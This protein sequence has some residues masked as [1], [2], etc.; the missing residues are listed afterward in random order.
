MRK[1][2]TDVAVHRAVTARDELERLAKAAIRAKQLP[3]DPFVHLAAVT[4]PPGTTC[5]LCARPLEAGFELDGGAG[6]VVLDARCFSSWINVAVTPQLHQAQ[7]GVAERHASACR[8]TPGPV[9]YT[10]TVSASQQ[11]RGAWTIHLELTDN[12]GTI[13][14]QADIDAVT[15]LRREDA[16]AAGRQLIDR[17]VRRITET[18]S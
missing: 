6:A 17:W 7:A 1:G 18:S 9:P 11:T 13:V 16:E 4:V 3:S 14:E 10:A 8:M 15:F 5:S 12:T 2:Q